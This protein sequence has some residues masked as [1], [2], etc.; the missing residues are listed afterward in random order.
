MHTVRNQEM[1]HSTP[2][3]FNGLS[4]MLC[5]EMQAMVSKCCKT[6]G[7]RGWLDKLGLVGVI[8]VMLC[9]SVL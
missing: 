2:Q 6:Q 1:L 5:A 7:G 3:A 9:M 4:A 8:S